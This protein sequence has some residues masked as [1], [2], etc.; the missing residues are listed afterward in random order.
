MDPKMT[1]RRCDEA[2]AVWAGSAARPRDMAERLDGKVRIH[3]YI[4][5]R[6]PMSQYQRPGSLA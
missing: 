1:A 4:L 5:G 6:R 2:V 3:V